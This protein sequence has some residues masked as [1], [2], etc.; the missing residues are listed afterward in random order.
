MPAPEGSR[1]GARSHAMARPPL[2]SVLLMEGGVVLL[3]AALALIASPLIAR[4]ILLGGLLFLG[5]QAWFAWRVFRDRGA[6]SAQAVV[7]GFYRGEAGKFLLTGA[8][9]ALVFV[10]VKPLEPAALFG[11]FVVL[12]IA[13]TVVLVSR[14]L[15]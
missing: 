2:G 8:G 6:R 13:H 11:T 10:T 12:H 5:P 4:S 14:K 7:Q 9:F 3:V 15:I 1:S